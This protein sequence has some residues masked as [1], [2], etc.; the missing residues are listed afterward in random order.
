MFSGVDAH[1][2]KRHILRGVSLLV[3]N[4]FTA[5]FPVQV[6]KLIYTYVWWK[7]KITILFEPTNIMFM[8]DENF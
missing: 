2:Y 1:V 7:Y 5:N 6:L 4:K 8:I 3:Y